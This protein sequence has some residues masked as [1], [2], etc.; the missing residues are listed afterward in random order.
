MATTVSGASSV[1]LIAHG[2]AM[3]TCRRKAFRARGPLKNVDK[4]SMLNEVRRIR[5]VLSDQLMDG[6]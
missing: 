3:T 4:A 1:T 2:G 5:I 6:P